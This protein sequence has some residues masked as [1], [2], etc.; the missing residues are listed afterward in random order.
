MTELARS[1][2]ASSLLSSSRIGWAAG[3][4]LAL[5]LGLTGCKNKKNAGPSCT[6]DD[7]AFESVRVIIQPDEM[8]NPNDEGEPLSVQLHVYQLSGDESVDIID[9]ETV[10]EKGGEVAFGDDFI[11]EE[12]IT[13]YPGKND[14][15]ELTPDPAAK[16]ILA[17][18]IF[19][20][21]LGQDWF[22]LYEVP[23]YHG[24]SVCSAKKKGQPWPDPCFH[25]ALERYLLDGGHT[26]P[27]GWDKDAQTLV[28]PGPPMKTP[29]VEVKDDGKK[30]KKK[31]KRKKLKDAEA[32]E[33][34]EQ[35]EAPAKPEAPAAPGR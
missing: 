19:R 23:R 33:Q 5:A 13:V 20:E 16:F 8:L 6:P 9:F 15:L 24:H 35:P 4:S 18:A 3:L 34:P 26:P 21:P 17:A 10:W 2:H 22:R 32:P 25:V 31:K 28:C 11:S 27:S 12:E 30:K 7:E 29:P 14:V 1:H